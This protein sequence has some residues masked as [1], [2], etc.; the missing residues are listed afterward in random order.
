MMLAP[1]SASASLPEP[2]LHGSLCFWKCLTL[3]YGL[4]LSWVPTRCMAELPTPGADLG[5]NS[6]LGDLLAAHRAGTVGGSRQLPSGKEGCPHPPHGGTAASS[7]PCA[8]ARDTA[9]QGHVRTPGV[10][11]VSCLGRSRA[12]LRAWVQPCLPDPAS[13]WMDPRRLTVPD[14]QGPPGA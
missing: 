4:M 2:H 12:P 14:P 8:P 10:Q 11:D 3:K 13:G 7:V 5:W 1:R 9:Q 6:E